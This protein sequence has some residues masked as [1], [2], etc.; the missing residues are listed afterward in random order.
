MEMRGLILEC[1]KKY[2]IVIDN[3]GN[4][5]R[6][7]TKSGYI[8]GKEIIYSKRDIYISSG[9]RSLVTVSAAIIMVLCLGV[10]SYAIPSGYVDIDAET[11]IGF[12]TNIYDRIINVEY[13]D[14]EAMKA[15]PGKSFKHRHIKDVIGELI[16]IMD[17][18]HMND[19]EKIKMNIMVKGRTPEKASF[20]QNIIKGVMDKKK[21]DWDNTNSDVGVFTREEMEFAKEN[22]IKP[23]KMVLYKKLLELGF[24]IELSDLPEI[25]EKELA[26]MYRSAM[27]EKNGKFIP[28]EKRDNKQGPGR[29]P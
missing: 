21:P 10:V 4:Y 1:R 15:Y 12:E 26:E 9:K 6:L 22:K 27:K 14:E 17:K 2:V 23:G 25:D 13:K 24:D 16:D 5:T 20:I 3:S 18:K 19:E 29:K 8:K 11:G 28:G 7:K